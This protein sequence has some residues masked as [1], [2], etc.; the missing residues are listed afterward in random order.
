MCR[1]LNFIRSWRVLVRQPGHVHLRHLVSL[2]FMDVKDEGDVALV[3]VPAQLA[4]HADIVVAEASVV[5]FEF[6]DV[7]IRHEGVEIAAQDAEQR[8]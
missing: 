2:P 7:E 5:F 8:A 6:G 3:L 1:L 4:G